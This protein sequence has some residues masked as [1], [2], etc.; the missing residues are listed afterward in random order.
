MEAVDPV[1]VAGRFQGGYGL[2]AGAA[3]ELNDPES[4]PFQHAVDF[5]FL[6]DPLAFADLFPL[7]CL[8]RG[9]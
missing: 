1:F 2:R 3:N 7:S 6:A 8:R 9:A 5:V 4:T